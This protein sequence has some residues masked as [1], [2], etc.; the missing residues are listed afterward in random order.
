M[1]PLDGSCSASKLIMLDSDHQRASR[2]IA[3]LHSVQ[4]AASKEI[5]WRKQTIRNKQTIRTHWMTCFGFRITFL[6]S[7]ANITMQHINDVCQNPKFYQIVLE[8]PSSRTQTQVSRLAVVLWILAILNAGCM[9]WHVTGP[10]LRYVCVSHSQT[11]SVPNVGHDILPCKQ[12]ADMMYE[13]ASIIFKSSYVKVE[14]AYAA[15]L[16]TRREG[17]ELGL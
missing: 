4:S 7:L 1:H 8:H 6:S 3:C 16:S 13:Q 11:C 5:F 12:N 10:F 9:V 2:D 15:H 14:V 17:Y